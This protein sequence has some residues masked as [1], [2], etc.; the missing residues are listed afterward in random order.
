MGRIWKTN[1]INKTNS[2]IICNDAF[3]EALICVKAIV[4]KYNQKKINKRFIDEV[5]KM[6]EDN[7]I[8]VEIKFVTNYRG[9]RENRFYLY[10]KGDIYVDANDNA[11]SLSYDERCIYLYPKNGNEYIDDEKRL[12]ADAFLNSIHHNFEYCVASN[13]D[14]KNGIK[15][16][17]DV[18]KIYAELNNI[19]KDKLK[20]IPAC[21]KGYSNN[22]IECPIY[23]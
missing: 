12:N 9:E 4:P 5:N 17:D 15:M 2:T 21:L 23:D 1:F 14:Y 6:F 10:Y 8:K 20:N 3:K 18:I 13:Q 16:A 7:N 11:G 19:I 22:H